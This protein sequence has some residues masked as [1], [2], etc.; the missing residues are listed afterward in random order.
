[1][2]NYSETA[3]ITG[4][5]QSIVFAGGASGAP[6]ALWE[7]A[8]R[9]AGIQNSL[10]G[11]DIELFATTYHGDYPTTEGY[12]NWACC[13]L[14]ITSQMCSIWLAPPRTLSTPTRSGTQATSFGIWA[15]WFG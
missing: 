7:D 9:R 12:E 6:Q 15:D 8:I 14:R 3:G 4:H 13:S 10:D 2:P 11:G 5:N 1:M